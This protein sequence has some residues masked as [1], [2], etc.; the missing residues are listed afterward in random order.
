M[1]PIGLVEASSA[2]VSGV[3]RLKRYGFL[4]SPN[5]AGASFSK[6]TL[7][8]SN[9]V[10]SD[11]PSGFPRQSFGHQPIYYRVRD[12]RIRL[13]RISVIGRVKLCHP[14]NLFY[15]L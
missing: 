7:H 12:L 9:R 5:S 14:P 6:V 11:V 15:M 4:E 8:K 1:F 3:L 2:T 13:R 10:V